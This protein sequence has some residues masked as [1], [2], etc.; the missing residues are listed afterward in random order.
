[1]KPSENLSHGFDLGPVRHKGPVNQDHRQ[2]QRT[3]GVQLGAGARSSSVFGDDMG[4]VVGSQQS[5]VALKAEGAARYDRAGLWQRQTCGRIDKAQKV[6]MLGFYG[7]YLKVLATDGEE[8]FGGVIG[9]RLNGAYHIRDRLPAVAEAG[10]PRLTLQGQKGQAGDFG[11][12]D[13]VGAH[14]RGEGVG[15]VDQVSDVFGAQV[16]DEALD[17]AEAT[18]ALGQGLLHRAF[19]SSGIGE[20]ARNTLISQGFGKHRG[21][22]GAAEQKDTGHG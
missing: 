8:D 16:G 5:K 18:D 13:G 21:F 19:R 20:D 9:Q 1:M 7:E 4:D 12:F 2:V 11:G 6:M 17:A 10:L 22:G 15:G 3:G 14:L